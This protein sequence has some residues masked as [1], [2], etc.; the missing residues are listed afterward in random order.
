MSIAGEDE[1]ET[2]LAL[3]KLVRATEDKLLGTRGFFPKGLAYVRGDNTVTRDMALRLIAEE[4]AA[5]KAEHYIR[6]VIPGLLADTQIPKGYITGP[7]NEQAA[8]T[9]ASKLLPAPPAKRQ[10]KHL[11]TKPH[12]NSNAGKVLAC[13][14]PWEDGISTEEV[15]ARTG[16]AQNQAGPALSNLKRSGLIIGTYTT[17]DNKVFKLWRLPVKVEKPQED[18]AVINPPSP[19]LRSGQFWDGSDTVRLLELYKDGREFDAGEAVKAFDGRESVRWL[20]SRLTR[21]GYLKQVGVVSKD[22]RTVQ[23]YVRTDK[24]YAITKRVQPRNAKGFVKAG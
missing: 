19:A 17:T 20:V 5:D 12:S 23:R 24:G 13:F 11:P 4:I 8:L 14:K 9:A 18:P 7:F 21:A 3:N 6:H 10:D 16:L 1:F 15:K 2:L 22:G